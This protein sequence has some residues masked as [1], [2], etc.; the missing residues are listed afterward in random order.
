MVDRSRAYR[1]RWYIPVKTDVGAGLSVDDVS[2]GGTD[3][4][5]ASTLKG[6]AMARTWPRGAV[7]E[8]TR[9]ARPGD[10]V[11]C[12]LGQIA[13]WQPSKRKLPLGSLIDLPRSRRSE[14]QIFEALVQ[15]AF[16]FARSRNLL[17][18]EVADEME[19]AIIEVVFKRATQP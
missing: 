14:L 6:W 4:P 8:I 17:K 19:Q 7:F 9:Q 11:R 15:R 18:S 10:S 16:T 13:A 2:I 1:L 5:T 3:H 12:Y